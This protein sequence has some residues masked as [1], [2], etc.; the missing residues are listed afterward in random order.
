MH[1]GRTGGDEGNPLV[2]ARLD[3]VPGRLLGLGAQ[4]VVALE[5][6]RNA[7]AGVARHHHEARR[8]FLETG[9]DIF[10]AL[11][12]GDQ[13]LDVVDPRRH[14]QDDRHL[15]LF[16]QLEGSQG[17][18][19]GFLRIGRLEQRHMREAAPVAGILFVLRGRQTDVVGDGDDQ[20]ADHAG[21]GQGHQRIG[22]D[23]HADMLHAAEGTR[24]GVGGADGYFQRHLL[25]HRPLGI[26][27][28]IGRDDFQHFRGRRAGIGRSDLD[29][30]LPDC[31]GDRFVT[32][33]QDPAC[34]RCRHDCRHIDSSITQC[35]THDSRK[36]SPA[37]I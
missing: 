33:H 14:A 34:C 3:D 7:L 1:V 22:G 16:R 37:A 26:D 25:V 2:A 29:T 24:A 36:V 23:V 5:H 8:V 9:T 17:H 21:Q 19:V 30:R 35:E 18:G 28:R 13:R 6:Q 27:V 4:R 12:N 20:A 15:I 32:R 11:A 10:L 31:T